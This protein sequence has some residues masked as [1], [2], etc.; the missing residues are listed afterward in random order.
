MMK[1]LSIIKRLK[2]YLKPEYASYILPLA[3]AALLLLYS[4][5]AINELAES[6]V[7][8]E[9]S[10]T[11]L[12]QLEHL[13]SDVEAAEAAHYGYLMT[14]KESF[15]Q[16]YYQAQKRIPSA[17]KELKN[18][19]AD[20]AAQQERL[21]AL[22]PIIQI[23]FN[24]AKKDMSARAPG[25]EQAAETMTRTK[26]LI[27]Q[28]RALFEQLSAEENMQLRERTAA[29]ATKLHRLRWWLVGIGL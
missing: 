8:V 18:L 12:S 13:R 3:A 2:S 22:S 20:N 7:R 15:L 9:H 1:L 5:H 25:P 19:T 14:E 23:L 11:V 26:S 24:Q 10:Y 16:S 28:S 27:D 17:L 21:D 6:R 29:S 4:Q